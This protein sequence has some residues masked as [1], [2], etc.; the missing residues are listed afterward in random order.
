VTNPLAEF[1]TETQ[2]KYLKAI[3][4]HGGVTLAARALG[5]HHSAV[6][7]SMEALRKNAAS[8][9]WSPKHNWRHPVPETHNAARVSSHYTKGILD[10]QWVIATLDEQKAKEAREAALQAL[11]QTIPRLPPI[12][13][14]KGTSEHLCNVYTLTDCHVGMLAWP[15]ETGEPWDLPIAE[16]VLT[17]CFEQM[18]S[19]APPARLAYVSQLGDFLHSDGMKAV[20]PEHGHLLDQ[21]GRFPKVVDAAIRVLRKVVDFALHRHERVVVL[22]AEGNHDP[23]SSIWLRA[24]FRALYE[25]EPRIQVVD[26]HYPYYAHQHGTTMLAFHHGHLKKTD[27]LPELF[28]AAF[29]PLWG[30]TTKRYCHTGHRH[31]VEE[32]EHSGMKV[33]QHPTL[34][35]KDAYAARGGWLAMRQA[36]AITYHSSFGEVARN[37]ICPEMLSF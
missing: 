20:T 32:K 7:R 8:K 23:A 4:E 31:H 27:S 25:N 14:P 2:K 13:A 37:T 26:S 6:G 22:L 16:R 36:T 15:Q 19:A 12:E 18:V 21:D 30:A 17:G 24:M 33:L 34:A 5:V 11:V 35:A 28:A 1:A 9:G 29:S 10:Q 3:D